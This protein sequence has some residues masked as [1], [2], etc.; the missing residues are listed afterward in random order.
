MPA[1][2]IQE[3]DGTYGQEAELDPSELP[4]WDSLP[5]VPESAGIRVEGPP[6]VAVVAEN[7]PSSPSEDFV[8]GSPSRYPE[9]PPEES[10][11]ILEAVRGQPQK[12]S[13]KADGALSAG[14]ASRGAVRGAG[15]SGSG[16]PAAVEQTFINLLGARFT[17]LRHVRL[18]LAP[19]GRAEGA[20][21]LGGSPSELGIDED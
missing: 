10:A 14:G 21:G 11:G 17:G 5:T 12:R 2:V 9:D 4:S 6:T 15:D 19:A 20:A 18:D 13:G 8:E 7:Q 16:L 3:G 1:L